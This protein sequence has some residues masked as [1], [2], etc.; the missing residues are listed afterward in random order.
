M[1]GEI[2]IVASDV[3][4]VTA[5]ELAARWRVSKW[6]VHDALKKGGLRGF[7]LAGAKR[8]TW[9]IPVSEVARYE[10]EGG[11]PAQ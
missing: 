2:N 3:Q 4:C 10:R 7:Q 1:K 8:R 6:A 5:N 11:N 9:R